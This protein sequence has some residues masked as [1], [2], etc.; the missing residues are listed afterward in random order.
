MNLSVGRVLAAPYALGFVLCAAAASAQ[1][2]GTTTG[3]ISG[4]V[5]DVTGAMLPEVSVAVMGEALMMP[6][7]D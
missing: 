6:R 5:T 1:T 3:A 7:S 4:A 2:L